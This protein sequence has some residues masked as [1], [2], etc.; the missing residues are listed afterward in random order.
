MPNNKDNTKLAKS[1]RQLLK[2]SVAGT[3]ALVAGKSLPDQWSRPL[4]ESV[5]L[6]A[7][8]ETSL[9]GV[10]GGLMLS[11]ENGVSADEFIFDSLIPSANAGGMPMP[12]DSMATAECCCSGGDDT[13]VDVKALVEFVWE[14]PEDEGLDQG[15]EEVPCTIRDVGYFTGTVKSGER[16]SLSLQN[17][18]CFIPDEP[19]LQC[20]ITATMN[21]GT[22]RGNLEFAWAGAIFSSPFVFEDPNCPISTIPSCN[23]GDCVI[24]ENPPV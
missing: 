7:H 5:V 3:G 16:T 10:G 6:P 13:P 8:A 11:L 17:G 18:P 22:C 23:Q 14:I 2:A 15:L 21:G 4:V 19:G 24:D 12:S 9:A 20:W 1:R